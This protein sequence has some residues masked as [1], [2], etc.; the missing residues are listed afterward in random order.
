MTDAVVLGRALTRIIGPLT[1]PKG[2]DVFQAVCPMGPAY[3]AGVLVVGPSG[4]G[5]TSALRP[6]ITDLIRTHTD[7]TLDLLLAD[8]KGADSFLMFTGQPGVSAVVTAPDP[9]SGKPDPIPDVVRQFHAEVQRRYD[10]LQQ[11]K[12][13]A[14]LHREP[15]QWTP[16]SLCVLV[17]DEYGD[18]N[19]GLTPKLRGEMVKILTRCGQIGREVN[20]RLWLAMQAPY[21][22]LADTMLPGLLK[23][24]LSIRIA[25][26]GLVG[27][28]E[29]LG[30]MLFD[31]RDAG[32]RLERAATAAGLH[33]DDRRGLSMVQLGR[34][35]VPFKAARM[36]DPLH[37]ETTPPDAEKAWNLLPRRPSTAEL[38]RLLEAA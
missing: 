28:P 36:A 34:L 26:A 17:L 32:N 2:E 20:C 19:L 7:D 31:D 11:A 13:R 9:A 22:K 24:Q 23:Q 16:P 27:I 37:W 8:A 5:K 12:R 30:G 4:A 33:G 15:V 14:I 10:Q 35:E 38:R 25:I 18:W 21:A 1:R 6:P 29:T 3:G